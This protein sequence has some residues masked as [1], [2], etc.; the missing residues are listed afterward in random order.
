MTELLIDGKQV[1]LP[2]GMDL[3]VK[4]QN[5][6][7]TKN[8]TFTLDL[9]LSLKERNNSIL[10]KH[11]ERLQS[12]AAIKGRKAL[13]LSNGRIILNGT[14]AIISNTNED[15]KIQLLSGNSELN[16]FINSDVYISELDLGKEPELTT[17]YIQKNGL[18]LYPQSSFFSGMVKVDTKF[19]NDSS[20]PCF[21]PYLIAMLEKVIKALGYTIKVNELL[22]EQLAKRL[23]F[24]NN[25]QST[26]YNKF[27]PGWK[28]SDF[29]TECETFFNI[30]FD[31]SEYDKS[32]SILRKTSDSRFG[33]YVIDNV[34]DSYERTFDTA[35]NDSEI[36]Y[37]NIKYDFSS[38]DWYKYQDIDDEIMSK[39][40]II[41]VST[42]DE[43]CKMLDVKLGEISGGWIPVAVAEQYYKTLTIFYVVTSDTYYMVQEFHYVIT[44]TGETGEATWHYLRP[45]N[46]FKK[47]LSN[48]DDDFVSLKFIPAQMLSMPAG[49]MWVWA[50]SNIPYQSDKIEEESTEEKDFNMYIKNGVKGFND[51]Q[52]KICLAISKA[53]EEGE[54][55]LVDRGS[56]I[57][58]VLDSTFCGENRDFKNRTLR[59]DGDYGLFQRYYNVNRRYD[60]SKAYTLKFISR[61]IPDVRSEFI[62]NNKLFICKEL[63]YRVL[64]DGIHPEITGTFYEVK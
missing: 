52:K 38:A 47:V 31:I 3:K 44:G 48:P 54:E 26:E 42:Y 12:S 30:A 15:V 59:I 57:D 56:P 8:G 9:T 4:Q 62:F 20:N 37:K 32:V 24:L 41:N 11:I 64:N 36:S 53:W 49:S 14:E 10:Y 39:A 21:Q 51:N 43:L 16:Y 18:N 27:L 2:K 50:V 19:Y 34:I 29:I 40:I 55:L 58:Y 60:V 6:L 23:Y 46:R 28:A 61:D 22:E 35:N 45:I 25:I 13:L 7:I 1:V 33:T 63:E 17:D 5:P